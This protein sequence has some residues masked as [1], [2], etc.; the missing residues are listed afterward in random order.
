MTVL[1]NLFTRHGA[2][3]SMQKMKTQSRQTMFYHVQHKMVKKDVAAKLCVTKSNRLQITEN[4]QNANS[5][6]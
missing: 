1:K 6:K 3:L 2:N 5:Q 4:N